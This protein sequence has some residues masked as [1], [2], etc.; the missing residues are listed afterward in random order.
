VS[1]SL[2]LIAE[3]SRLVLLYSQPV[4]DDDRYEI[5]EKGYVITI[6]RFVEGHKNKVDMQIKFEVRNALHFVSCGRVKQ[7]AFRS[8][9]TTRDSLI[10]L[11]TLNATTI[12]RCL[13]VCRCAVRL[14]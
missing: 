7:F 10:R 14:R 12:S 6:K 1:V 5:K 13:N 2:C 3:T 11:H 8:S 9:I 4:R